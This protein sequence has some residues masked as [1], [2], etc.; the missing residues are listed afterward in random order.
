MGKRKT[1]EGGRKGE[2]SRDKGRRGESEK[3][4]RRGRRV[5]KLQRKR[6]TAKPFSWFK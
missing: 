1:N 5:S 3:G 2:E 6:L 4:T